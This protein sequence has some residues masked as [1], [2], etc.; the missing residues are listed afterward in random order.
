M[1]VQYYVQ[2]MFVSSTYRTTGLQDTFRSPTL[3]ATDVS[4]IFLQNYWVTLHLWLSN[5]QCNLCLLALT[6]GLLG[7]TTLIGALSYV[8]AM[9]QCSAYKINGYT[10]NMGALLYVPAMFVTSTYRITELDYPYGCS[11]LSAAYDGKL[12][13]LNNWFSLPL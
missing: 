3:S 10:K 8:Q 4:K 5:L 2:P 9:L 13:L 1:G 7:Y 12:Y 6:T 11:S